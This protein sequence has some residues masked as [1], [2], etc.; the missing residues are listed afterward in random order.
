[1]LWG[2]FRPYILN[3][4]LPPSSTHTHTRTYTHTVLIQSNCWKC[5]FTTFL[6]RAAQG[7]YHT[8]VS[9]SI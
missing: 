1:M 9:S 6:V 3:N 4:I 7:Q 8:T 5:S 2:G